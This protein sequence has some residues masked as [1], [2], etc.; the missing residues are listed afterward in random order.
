MN[1]TINNNKIVK[2]DAQDEMWGKISHEVEAV[3]SKIFDAVNIILSA[4]SNF[5]FTAI[6]QNINPSIEDILRIMQV[7]EF[8]LDKFASSIDDFSQ[9]RKIDNAAQMIWCVKG[10][11]IAIKSGEV[12]DYEAM[13]EKMRKQAQH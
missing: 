1:N 7:T 10:L 8:V 3:C 12:A 13:I 5:G 6:N 2:D 11:V 9:K 4:H